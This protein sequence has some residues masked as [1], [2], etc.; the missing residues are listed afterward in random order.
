MRKYNDTRKI[1]KWKLWT[2]SNDF[3][4]VSTDDEDVVLT[5]NSL[6]DP[7]LT[8]HTF[9]MVVTPAQKDSSS[10]T[11][12]YI[13]RDWR[14]IGSN[15]IPTCVTWYVCTSSFTISFECSRYLTA[16]R[17]PVQQWSSQHILGSYSCLLLWRGC[18]RSGQ[19]SVAY[20]HHKSWH[21]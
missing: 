17:N 4:E 2:I 10:S 18:K 12:V 1:L 11:R 19:L 21:S 15:L 7:I 16:L 20:I 8:V 6:C 3:K 14:W 13:I 5:K 9:E